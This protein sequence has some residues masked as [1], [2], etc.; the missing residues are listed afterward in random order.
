MN[1]KE[2]AEIKKNFNDE[3]GLFSFNR[4]VLAYIDGE[5]EVRCMQNKGYAELDAEEIEVLFE[6]LKKSL[7]G[8]LG[9]NLTEYPFP[10]EAY[11]E[12]GAQ[13]IFYAALKCG[14]EDEEAV[15]AA[16][17]R[18][19][20][21]YHTDGV[22]CVIMAHCTYSVM[23]KNKNDELTDSDDNVYNFIIGAFCPMNTNADGLFYNSEKGVI[24][25][26][27]NTE[28]II[29]RAPVDGFLYPV[30]SDRAPDINH[31]MCYTK[32]PKKPNLTLIEDVMD[33]RFFMTAESEKEKF[34]QVLGEVVGD[35]LDY[36]VITKVNEI[37]KE[38]V[39]QNKAETE[40]AVIDMPV[41]KSILIDA[42]VSRDK[43]EG[44]ESA[45][46]S[47]V[48]DEK[49]GFTASNL[50]DNKTVVAIPEITVNIGGDAAEKVRTG[51]ISGKKCLIIDIDE[52]GIKI[53]GLETVLPEINAPQPAA[54]A[55]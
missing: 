19:R 18:I 35:E 12:G 42:G 48:G 5:G 17:G 6:T 36:T 25:K 11:E 49:T 26:K 45:F 22:Y 46:T 31:I 44:L 53:N 30:F 34:Q 39:D 16:V 37:I 21:N 29:S 10:N 51:V 41:M 9:K 20:E 14:L 33:C 50:V 54:A 23:S 55:E 4:A 32:T 28:L 47:A 15:N 2:I 27:D 38:V 1:K 8:S 7:S 3:N 40:P 52:P 43:L 24:E 13:N